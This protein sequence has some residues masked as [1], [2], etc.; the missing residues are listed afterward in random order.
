MLCHSYSDTREPSLLLA[1]QHY[2]REIDFRGESRLKVHNLSNAV[3]LDYDYESGCLY[4]SEVSKYVKS[5]RR[6]CP[7]SA[8]FQVNFS[9]IFQKSNI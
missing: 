6:Q 8:D 5:I 3:G 9:S 1:N 4:W 7:D 2:I